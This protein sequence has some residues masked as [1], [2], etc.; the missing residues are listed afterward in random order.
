MDLL[1]LMCYGVKLI[2]EAVIHFIAVISTYT[3]E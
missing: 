3:Y 1:P 2:L